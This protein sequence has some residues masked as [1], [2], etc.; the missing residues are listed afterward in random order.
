K[1]Q[2]TVVPAAPA[3]YGGTGFALT[4]DGYVV[5]NYHVTEGADSIYIQSKEGLHFRASL[6]GFDQKT[7]LAILK[8][9]DPEFR[10]AK[11]DIPY[12]FAPTK[13]KLGSKIFTLG[14][15]QEEIVYNEGYISAVNGY[16]GDTLQY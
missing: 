14:F 8:V 12:S 7:D 4:N 15:P 16:N 10:F 11:A 9:D 3:K 1:D 6:V 5:T 13:R 2:N